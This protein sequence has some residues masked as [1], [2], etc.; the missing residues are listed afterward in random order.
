[1]TIFF[2]S[3]LPI[4]YPQYILFRK[5]SFQPNVKKAIKSVIALMRASFP[6][7][8]Q[9][10]HSNCLHTRRGS[11]PFFFYSSPHKLFTKSAYMPIRIPLLLFLL[12][13]LCII[14]ANKFHSHKRSIFLLFILRWPLPL[15]KVA[16]SPM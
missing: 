8:G 15:A 3:H 9:S 14:F 10:L 1:M 12:S 2:C 16:F 7:I 4:F 5:V 11:P 13:R 6:Y